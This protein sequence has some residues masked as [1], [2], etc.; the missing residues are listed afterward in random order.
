MPSQRSQAVVRAGGSPTKSIRTENRLSSRFRVQHPT[1]MASNCRGD[2]QLG[3][4]FDDTAEGVA[5]QHKYE[6]LTESHRHDANQCCWESSRQL[7]LAASVL[8]AVTG[9]FFTQSGRLDG[10]AVW[11]HV[12]VL[13]SWILHLASM[14]LGSAFFL[15]EER[16]FTNW[17]DFYS[18]IARKYSNNSIPVAQTSEEARAGGQELQRNSPRV[19]QM[20]QVGF[21]LAGCL[22]DV[23]VFTALIL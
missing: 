11:V 5:Q 22:L 19:L 12:E 8:L 2:Q 17:T 18:D 3:E 14:I 1:S 9:T 16:F 7:L 21:F 15:S 4:D 23:V 13:C 6:S 10:F 20:L